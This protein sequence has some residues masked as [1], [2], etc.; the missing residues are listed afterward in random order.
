LHT[1]ASGAYRITSLPGGARV[2][3]QLYKDGYVQQCAVSMIISGDLT[4]NLALVS[5]ANLTASPPPSAP[6]FRTLS[7]T[8]VQMTATG[9]QPVAGAS[10]FAGIDVAFEPGEDPAA[11][12]YSDAT[13]RFA[14]CGLLATDTVYLEAIDGTR[15]ANVS[16]AA[17]KISDIQITL[18]STMSTTMA[19]RPG[20]TTTIH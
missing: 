1:D 8:V 20:D 12:T 17:G 13:G 11:Y 15:V 5:R 16:V 9:L 10:V 3:V 7:G 19:L 18:P 4:L 2:W 14:L 6:G